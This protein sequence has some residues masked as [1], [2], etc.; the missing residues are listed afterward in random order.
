MKKII[1]SVTILFLSFCHQVKAQP[2]TLGAFAIAINQAADRATQLIQQAQQTGLVL[3]VNAG[4]QALVVINQAKAAYASAL[5]STSQTLS[6]QQQQLIS[7][8]NGTLDNI[9]NHILNNLTANLQQIVNTIPLSRKFPQLTSFDGTILSPSLNTGNSVLVTLNGN[10]LDIGNKNFDAYLKIGA[11]SY[12]NSTK[13]TQQI[14]FQIPS[15]VFTFV[16]T[17]VGYQSFSVEI[18]YKKGLLGSKKIALYNLNFILLPNNPGTYQLF[19]TKATDVTHSEN[20]SCPNLIW[21]SSENDIDATSGCN[22]SDNWVCDRNSVS[23]AL[24]REQGRKDHDWFDYGNAS[25]PTFVGWHFKTQHKGLGTS[26]KLTVTL[27]Y[28]R[29]KTVTEPVTTPQAVISLSWGSSKVETIDPSATWKLTYTEFDGRSFDF[30]S[31]E[32]SNPYLKISTAGN[33]I[34]II[35]IP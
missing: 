6:A 35:T 2:A 13:T 18:P 3:E 12:K 31:S 20:A 4:S 28:R 9:Q 29:Y 11:N 30:A 16:T 15:S 8:L 25:T 21:D 24:T 17:K 33:Q 23:Y 5:A 1:I 22:M 7:S 27:N 10:F 34:Q 14:T 32:Q 26:G 19:I